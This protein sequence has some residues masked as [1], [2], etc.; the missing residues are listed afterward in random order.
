[1][2]SHLRL[3]FEQKAKL[4][5]KA[6]AQANNVELAKELE[7]LR[8]QFSD[9]KVSNN[10]LS[11]HV[12]ILQAQITGEE[13]IKAAFEEFKKY[14]DDWVFADV[15][16]GG[17]AKCMN[18]GPKHTKRLRKYISAGWGVTNNCRLDTPV[19]CQDVVDHI[20]PPGYFSK[21]CHVP[22][23]DFLSQ[24]NINLARQVAMGS[25]LRLR[26]EQKAKL[27]KKAIA[28]VAR[29]DQSIEARSLMGYRARSTLSCHE[30]C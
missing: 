25:H 11:Q 30:V 21:L 12:S 20:V 17:I 22:N 29:R 19:V 9:L 7:S 27:L 10:Q 1:M 16:S 5:K 15:V 2:G 8:V 23:D 13:R 24:Y 6:I 26:F 3:R 4:L 18:E 28:Q 14:E